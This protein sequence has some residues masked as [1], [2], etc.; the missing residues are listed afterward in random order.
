MLFEEKS[1]T[2]PAI[3]RARGACIRNRI[4]P[5]GKEEEEKGRR[6]SLRSLTVRLEVCRAREV[7][8]D[9]ANF[10]LTRSN[11]LGYF[12]KVWKSDAIVGSSIEGKYAC[13]VT[14]RRGETRERWNTFC[15]HSGKLNM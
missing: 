8:R 4:K 14:A 12:G 1:A 11:E 15:E 2:I 9:L 13:H 6:R 7:R 5:G 3:C 10:S